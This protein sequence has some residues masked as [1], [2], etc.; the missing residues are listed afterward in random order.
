MLTALHKTLLILALI[1]RFSLKVTEPEKLNS[2]KTKSL[3]TGREFA[4]KPVDA[5]S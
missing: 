1:P 4:L 3:V 5:E 2:S